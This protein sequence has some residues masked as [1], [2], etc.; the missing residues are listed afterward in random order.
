MGENDG[1]RCPKP[2][3]PKSVGPLVGLSGTVGGL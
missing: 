2:V 1:M 3:I